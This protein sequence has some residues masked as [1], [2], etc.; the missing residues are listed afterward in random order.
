MN[1]RFIFLISCVVTF[2][3]INACQFSSEK[4]EKQVEPTA[5]IDS[6]HYELILHYKSDFEPLE[7]SKLQT[8]MSAIYAA[9]QQTMGDFPFDVHVYLFESDS[10]N[11]PVSFGLAQ[12]V[13]QLHKVN[14]YVNPDASL[15]ELLEDWTAPHELSHLTIPFL[16][17][18]NKWFTEGYATFFSRQILMDMGYYTQLSFDSLYFDKIHKAKKAF[19]SDSSSFSERALEVI[20]QHNYASFYSGGSSFF[21]TIDLRLRKERNMRFVD[22]IQAYQSCCRLSDNGI[23]DVVHSFDV[24]IGEPWCQ[25]LLDVYRNKSANEALIDYN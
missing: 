6:V 18:P 22:I 17:Q 19:D 15:D 4:E 9:T 14:L 24:L 25:E 10:K 21:M 23:D 16:G 12:F 7:Q 8:W 5:T 3:F 13:D 11:T 20:E 1:S 2:V